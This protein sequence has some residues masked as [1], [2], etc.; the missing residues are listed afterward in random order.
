MTVRE[1]FG[2][3]NLFN[4]VLL[5]SFDKTRA[6][7]LKK[8]AGIAVNT[9]LRVRKGEQVL[10]I[11]NPLPDSMTIS[12]A[13]YDAAAE[14]GG[15]PTLLV[16]PVKQQI[17]FAE[18][19]V[20]AAFEARPEVVISIS[21]VKLGK[22]ERGI[23]KPYERDGKGYD[24]I[25]HLLQ[26]G[27]KTT[28]AFWSPSVT[29]DAFIRTLP[30]DYPLLQA[31]CAAIGA[32]L[33]DAES[34]RVSAP[35]GTKIEFGLRGRLA[36]SDDGNFSTGGTGGNLPAGEV[37]ISPENNTAKGVIVFDGAISVQEGDIVIDEPIVC[38]VKGGFVTEIRGGSEADAL[39]QTVDLA[40]KNSRE[41]EAHGK[42]P[43]GRGE[44]YAKN[45]RNIGELGIGLNPAAK[46]TGN[47]L[48]DEKVFKTCH[49]AIGQNYDEDA[50]ALIHLDGLVRLP[51]IT[52]KL[53][54]GKEI[55]IERDGELQS[56]QKMKI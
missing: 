15:R 28:R 42:L 3:T 12:A 13:L 36:K 54:D 14:A 53:K 52:V 19:A 17:D 48:E 21:S 11:A 23:A 40:A 24:H 2:K 32:I 35:G 7:A 45:A 4:S 1:P 9:S 33:N 22:D 49:F 46:I 26:Y 37:F 44:V 30:I 38:T 55:V 16:Q 43:K 5:Q 18:K 8:A 25:F 27:E 34:M 6:G 20:I 56:E 29:I 39:R 31:R 10:I 51:T 41:F 47:M 50:P